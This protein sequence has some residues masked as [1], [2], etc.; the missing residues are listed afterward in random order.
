MYTY[1]AYPDYNKNIVNIPNSILNYFGVETVGDTLRD[2]DKFLDKEYKN[3]ILLVLDGVGH[4]VLE[5]NLKRKDT[6]IRHERTTVSSVFPSATVAATT[7]LITGQMPC[8]HAWLGWD[9]YYKDIDKNVTVFN[10]TLQGSKKQA[11]K[12]NVAQTLTP[13]KSIMERLNEAGID[14]YSVSPFVDPRPGSFSEVL[15]MTKKL[16][17]KPGRKYIYAYWDKTDEILHKFGGA[18][19]EEEN[20]KAALTDIEKQ[21][22]SFTY[23]MKDTLL[24]ITADHGH[25][26]CN[27][28]CIK[29]H[30][31]LTDCLVRLPSL[32]PRLLNFFVKEGRKREFRSLFKKIYGDEFRLM[33]KKEVLD[34]KLFG[35]GTEHKKFRSMLGDYFAVATG[36]S[37]ITVN[38]P[39]WISTHGGVVSAEMKVPLIIINDFFTNGTEVENYIDAAFDIL[40]K[41]YPWAKKSMFNPHYSY[42]IEKKGGRN[43]FIQYYTWD[44]GEKNRYD[45]GWDGE[46]FI[47][48]I[49]NDNE[50]SIQF[51]NEVTEVFNVR[52]D[53]GVDAHGWRL[54]RFEFRSHKLGGYSAFVQ[55]GDRVTGGSRTFFFSPEEMSGSFE[56]FLAANKELF[57]GSFGLTA[58]YM[59]NFSGLKEFLGFKE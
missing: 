58:D 29:D 48:L 12:Y 5:W 2:L 10:N 59:K 16:C 3:V 34:E 4:T 24:I 32:E 23:K 49:V 21:I 44:N 8:E 36:D 41:R 11:A 50:L 56:D 37:G 53:Y 28:S 9:T 54:E 20:I 30:P 6:L 26:D 35:T 17:A 57:S 45:E 42:A 40:K 31:E 43:K 25:I 27:L 52:P 51:A 39:K 1:T 14:A 15:D 7:S 55:A 47:D 38:K 13:Y 22:A 18:S 19:N 33:T 46:L